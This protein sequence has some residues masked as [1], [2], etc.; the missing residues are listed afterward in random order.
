[1]EGNNYPNYWAVI[2]SRVRYDKNLSPNA[3]LIYG[4][5]SALSNATGFCWAKNEYFADLFGLTIGTISRLISQLDSK[6]YI[7][8]EM[9]PT[10]TGLERRIYAGIFAVI[11]E[12]DPGQNDKGGLAENDKVGLAENDKGGLAEND[13]GGLNKNRKQNNININIYTPH[14]PQGG[15]RKHKEPREAPDWE[16]D[17][18]QGLWKF[19]PKEGRKNKQKAMDAW[20]KLHPD[21]DLI[22]KIARSLVKLKDTD[23]WKRGIGIPHV[24]TFLN[25]ARWTDADELDDPDPPDRS[26]GWA[27]DPE[28]L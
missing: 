10:D 3:K 17:R 15:K 2:P 9:V 16:P 7:R 14:T 22:N 28:V 24:A 20:D 6:G 23:D 21:P 13:K 11:V 19:Y 18:F 25:G 4:E 26:G 5:I 27:D 1:M 8:C 12:Y